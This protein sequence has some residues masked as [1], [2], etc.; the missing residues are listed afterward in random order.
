[1]ASG[2]ELQVPVYP[3]DPDSRATVESPFCLQPPY[4][5]TLCGQTEP[6]VSVGHSLPPGVPCTNLLALSCAQGSSPPLQP[7]PALRS[8]P[9][10]LNIKTQLVL[11]SLAPRPPSAG[12]F[13]TPSGRVRGLSSVAA[14]VRPFLTGIL[15][16]LTTRCGSLVRLPEGRARLHTACIQCQGLRAQEINEFMNLTVN[17]GVE[18][19]RSGGWLP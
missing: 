12:A 14:T 18:R 3:S 15:L 19:R 6:T 13:L 10:N 4:L 17:A 2:P 11:Q 16:G 7:S 8:T 9:A 1:M 5:V